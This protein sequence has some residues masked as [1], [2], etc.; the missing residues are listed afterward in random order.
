M[1]SPRLGRGAGY[2]TPGYP[3]TPLVYIVVMFA[4]LVSVATIRLR[5]QERT[6]P[7][8]LAQALGAGLALVAARSAVE[9]FGLAGALAGRA[10]DADPPDWL[11]AL[12]PPEWVERYGRRFDDY[13]F[14]QGKPERYV[15]AETIGADGFRRLA[16]KEDRTGIANGILGDAV[17]DLRNDLV[18][19]QW[20]HTLDDPGNSLVDQVRLQ[21]VDVVPHCRLTEVP[22][23]VSGS[24][25]RRLDSAANGISH[26]RSQASV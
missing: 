10:P 17:D 21:I 12:T 14:P 13:Q 9:A 19:E 3:L 1:R 11:R 15:L 2:R 24:T 18:D 26:G 7:L 25:H 20:R 22:G 4:F 8:F 16:A 5:T 23:R 6:R